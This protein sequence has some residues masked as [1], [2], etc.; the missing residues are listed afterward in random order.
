VS[1][2]RLVDEVKLPVFAEFV[3]VVAP[4]RP[5]S[6]P[7]ISFGVVEAPFATNAP[8]IVALV[9]P[10]DVAAFVVTPGASGSVVKLRIEP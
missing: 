7:Q 8:L 5:E 3:T 2:V 1:P 4:A 6:V 9:D 10:T